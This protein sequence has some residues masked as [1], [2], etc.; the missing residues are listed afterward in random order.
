MNERVKSIERPVCA[1]PIFLAVWLCVCAQAAYAL[2]PF[3]GIEVAN[4]KETPG[5]RVVKVAPGSL[6]AKAGIK[7]GD[8]IV[9]IEKTGVNSLEDFVD[10]SRGVSGKDGTSI[11]VD[12]GGSRLDVS[13][14]ESLSG[15]DSG[16]APSAPLPVIQAPR[17][18]EPAAPRSPPP[19]T[20]N[21]PVVIRV[22]LPGTPPHPAPSVP[23]SMAGKDVVAR[24]YLK[25]GVKDSK[26]I[27]DTTGGILD[28]SYES[29]EGQAELSVT[30]LKKGLVRPGGEAMQN[31]SPEMYSVV[32][33]S[34]S[35]TPEAFFVEPVGTF[36][37]N[38]IGIIEYGS[39]HPG[40]P[41]LD[42]DSKIENRRSERRA[43]GK[44]KS[45]E[46]DYETLTLWIGDRQP[47]EAPGEKIITTDKKRKNAAG[48]KGLKYHLS[49]SAPVTST[50]FI[51]GNK[52]LEQ[53]Q[54]LLIELQGT[55][56][57]GRHKTSI[58]RD[59]IKRQGFLP[60]L[61]GSHGVEGKLVDVSGTLE[62][63]GPGVSMKDTAVGGERIDEEN[64]DKHCPDAFS[65]R[66][67]YDIS[68]DFAES[69]VKI[70][71][72]V[73]LET[74]RAVPLRYVS[75]G[76]AG[77]GE[78]TIYVTPPTV[79]RQEPPPPPQ[80]VEVPKDTLEFN[81]QLWEMDI[82]D[83]WNGYQLKRAGGKGGPL[84]IKFDVQWADSE[85]YH[86]LVK[87]HP[88]NGRSDESDWFFNGVSGT[89]DAYADYVPHE[90][91][92]MLG[93]DDEYPETVCPRRPR[94]RDNSIMDDPTSR[95]K[96]RHFKQFADWLEKNTGTKWVV[97]KK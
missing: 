48:K 35:G 82:E 7:S 80:S 81:A 86:H 37:F 32:V 64:R 65:G 2:S 27:R 13:L 84:D 58:T 75:A 51:D 36:A 85:D 17:A 56:P 52:L 71:V 1:L 50:S 23:E 74:V 24:L 59:N 83:R 53:R 10:I 31:P 55:I 72:K 16:P 57:E 39:R 87:V 5:A 38:E 89:A 3:S 73:K 40:E 61:Y 91:G 14:G 63:F 90:F 26:N 97:K 88:G 54:P 68:V 18:Q 67:A 33:S 28:Y 42:D 96:A 70:V 94:F 62:Y 19:T 43:I 76:R 44:V 47:W 69:E 29:V 22:P 60:H 77:G 95:P 78:V 6:A 9:E 34:P 30:L 49:Y 41:N 79:G 93:L 11:S 45:G 92:H 8:V 25:W 15:S 20:T 4:S 66:K 46:E 21:N 12:R